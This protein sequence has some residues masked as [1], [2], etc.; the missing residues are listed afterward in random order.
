[1]EIDRFTGQLSSW[2]EKPCARAASC[3]LS[4][5]PRGP[6]QGPAVFERVRHGSA[7][8]G[9]GPRSPRALRDMLPGTTQPWPAGEAGTLAQAR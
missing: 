8:E 3:R 6:I 9:F 1:M 7:P 5:L 4:L 2:A